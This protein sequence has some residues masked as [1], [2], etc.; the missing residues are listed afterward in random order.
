[1]MTTLVGTST[2]LLVAGLMEASG[3][4]GLGLFDLA[5]AGV[6]AALAAITYFALAGHR[7]LPDR[8]PDGDARADGLAAFLFEVRV[9]AGS[10]LVGRTVEEAGLRDL[11]DAYLVHLRRAQGGSA[12][13]G[14]DEVIPSAPE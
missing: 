10:R 3:V 5:W 8:R 6:P 13:T 2:N 12:A 14:A 4:E 1:G 9:P 11:K 7:L